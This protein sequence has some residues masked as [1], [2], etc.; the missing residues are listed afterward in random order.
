MTFDPYTL[1]LVGVGP[2][3]VSTQTIDMSEYRVTLV[4]TPDP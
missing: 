4:V 2:D 1:R 3:P